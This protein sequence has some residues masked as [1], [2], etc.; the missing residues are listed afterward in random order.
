[1]E[2]H[3]GGQYHVLPGDRLR[4][5]LGDQRMDLARA[6]RLIGENVFPGVIPVGCIPHFVGLWGLGVSID[7]GLA[8]L[9]TQPEGSQRGGVAEV[10]RSQLQ[11]RLAARF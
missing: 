1:M 9:V 8:G 7:P 11:D 2:L 6:E 3:G 4:R 10:V 5:H